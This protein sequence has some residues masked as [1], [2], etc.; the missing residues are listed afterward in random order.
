L[1]LDPLILPQSRVQN[2]C[3]GLLTLTFAQT[4]LDFLLCGLGLGGS[5]RWQNNFLLSLSLKTQLFFDSLQLLNIG[6]MNNFDN[7]FLL[8]H[9][10]QLLQYLRF[11]LVVLAV[12]NT[13]ISPP[14]SR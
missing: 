1:W 8:L 4:S 2:W 12:L 11:Q 6:L 5:L 14:L 7:S 3:S 9:N 10:G 13:A